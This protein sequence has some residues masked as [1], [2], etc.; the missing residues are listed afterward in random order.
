MWARQ[1]MFLPDDAKMPSFPWIKR[2]LV[3]SEA[4][5]FRRIEICPNDCIAYWDSTYLP[6]KVKN[7]HRTHCPK[8]GVPRTV[9]DPV[10]GKERPA[11]VLYHFPIAPYVRDLFS[12]PDL[13]PHLYH[14]IIDESEGHVKRSR[15]YKEKVLDN[16]VINEDHRNLAFIGTT[17]G[18]PFFDDQKR[19][20]WPFLLKC[21][22]LPEGLCNNVANTH[23]TMLSGNEY[24][25]LDEEARVLR[26]RIRAPKSLTPHMS[27]IV[28]DLL[29]AYWRGALALLYMLRA[30]ILPFT[31]G[32][33]F[34]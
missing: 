28:D 1:Q 24:W 25:E 19:G 27:I 17:D 7:A 14:N 5:C 18:V 12:R 3:K 26:R 32:A 30:G 31:F 15:G 22:N 21:A 23:L 13:V 11:K 16:P 20:A 29:A 8:C 34:L 33:R 10:D 9:T 6:K 2:L 4:G